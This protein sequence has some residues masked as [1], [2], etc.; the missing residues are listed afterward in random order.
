VLSPERIYGGVPT[1]VWRICAPHIRA[2]F[3]LS[4][5]LGQWFGDSACMVGV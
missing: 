5:P 4:Q 1:A 2:D 3:A